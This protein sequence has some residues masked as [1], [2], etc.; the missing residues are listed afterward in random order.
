MFEDGITH[1][2][3]LCNLGYITQ[4]LKVNYANYFDTPENLHVN[5]GKKIKKENGNLDPFLL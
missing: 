1:L 4:D 5:S 2:L 3:Y